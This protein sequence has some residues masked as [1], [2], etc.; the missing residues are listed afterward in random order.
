[1]LQ[2]STE[3][4]FQTLETLWKHV[5]NASRAQG[6]AVST[7]RSNMTNNQIEMGCDRSGM[8]NTNKRSSK[9][10]TSREID[11]P[12]RLHARKYSKNITWTLKVQNPENS[13]YATENIM[14]HPDF[15]KFNEQE[16]SQ[17]SQ[18]SE[19]LIL[20]RKIQA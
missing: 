11:C 6:Y 2:P 8:P 16:T 10:V 12:F 7:F 18:M 5:N 4:G 1:M 19:S 14:A 17:I 13:H 3:G 15:M 20:P 9:T